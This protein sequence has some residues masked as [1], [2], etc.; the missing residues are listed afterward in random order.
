M[1]KKYEKGM[2]LEGKVVACVK[3]TDR[4]EKMRS[5]GHMSYFLYPKS[6]RGDSWYAMGSLVMVLL[7]TLLMIFIFFFPAWIILT[8]L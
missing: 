7:T 2:S 3:P 4:G 1:G 5:F 8:C 6:F